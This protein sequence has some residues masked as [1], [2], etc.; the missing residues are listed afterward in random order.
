M[1]RRSVPISE[2]PGQT[3]P[4]ILLRRL[5]AMEA[6]YDLGLTNK[7]NYWVLFSHGIPR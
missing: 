6:R 3:K 7:P 2:H 4:L 1:I 5:V